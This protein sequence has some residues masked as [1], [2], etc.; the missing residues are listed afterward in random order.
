[1]KAWE[2][3]IIGV[4]GWGNNAITGI[5]FANTRGQAKYYAWISCC[6]VSVGHMVKFTDTR[7]KRAKEYDNYTY[8]N[9]KH[10]DL[11]RYCFIKCVLRK[12]ETKDEKR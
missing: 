3:R 12:K 8:N 10:S 5:T 1:M 4:N 9:M 7:V 6:T 2:V 11:K